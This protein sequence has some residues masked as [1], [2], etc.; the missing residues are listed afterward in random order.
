MMDVNS[1][2]LLVNE[3]SSWNYMCAIYALIYTRNSVVMAFS[4]LSGK[5]ARLYR[6]VYSKFDKP[7]KGQIQEATAEYDSLCYSS[8]TYDAHANW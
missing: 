8:F 3:T 1:L 6:Q 7:V 5:P 2:S 4:T